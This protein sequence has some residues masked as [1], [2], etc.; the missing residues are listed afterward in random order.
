MAAKRGSE[1]K[2]G[3]IIA[4]VCFVVLTIAL[5]VTTYFGFAG[6]ADLEKKAAEASTAEKSAK[7]NRD[8]YKYQAV[9]LRDYCGYPPTNQEDAGA[10]ANL[11]SK[12]SSLSGAGKEEFNKIVEELKARMGWDQ[13]ANKS[14]RNFKGEVDRLEKDLAAANEKLAKSEETLKKTRADHDVAQATKEAE[15]QQW[16]KKAETAMTTRNDDRKELEKALEDRLAEFGN[17]STE[18]GNTKKKADEDAA[19][20][21]KKMKELTGV[22]KSLESTVR[23]Q[24]DQLEP[25]SALKFIGSAVKGKVVG[26]DPKGEVCWINVGSADNVRPNQG[27]TFSVFGAGRNGQADNVL[28][29]S[30]E[31]IDILERH[32]SMAKIVE[33]TDAGRN[34]IVKGDLL[35]NPAWSPSARQHVAIAGKIDLTGEG[36]DNIQEFMANLTR[37]GMV[38]DAYLDMVDRT[39]KGEGMTM[40]TNYL[41]VGEQPASNEREI[42]DRILARQQKAA[43]KETTDKILDDPALEQMK[44]ISEKMEE[45]RKEATDKGVTI[46]PLQKF[47]AMTGYRLPKGAGVTTG[48]GSEARSRKPSLKEPKPSEK[49]SE[50][51]EKKDDS[52]K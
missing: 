30:I 27:L 49:K 1:S 52:E 25:P 47:I 12:A 9:L 33:V 45:M 48:F 35:I 14:A 5:G 17:L 21:E 44:Q 34:P 15:V 31:V 18:L 50:K 28:K 41:I 43:D 40:D 24:R 32:L 8:W 10:L 26:L 11:G 20:A 39:V 51:D 16:K 4:L 36:R 2:Q 37:Q 7:D 22:N 38:V 23:K 3:L 29:G 19:G 42:A 46:V 6:Q 13:A